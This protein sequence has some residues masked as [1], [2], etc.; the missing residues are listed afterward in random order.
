[1]H[2]ALLFVLFTSLY[3]IGNE[4]LPLIDR[5][6]P[7]FA[8]A[9]REMRASGDYI[10]PRVN[11]EYRFDKPP[12]IYWLQVAA[13]DL[14]GDNEFAVRFP[15]V[16]FAAA[17][18]VA[19]A[20]WGSR[21]YNPKT[22][23]WAGLIFGLSFQLFIHA[24]AAVA[25]FPM[26]FCFLVATWSAWERRSTPRSTLLFWAFYL[27]LGIGF[28]AKGPIALLPILFPLLYQLTVR[29]PIRPNLASALAGLGVVLLVIGAWGVPALILT[30]GEF[31]AVGIGHHVVERSI[32]PL[33]SHGARTWV[34][35]LLGLP[36]YFL[37]FFFSFFPGWLFAPAA[38]R[39]L[40]GEIMPVERYLLIAAGCVFLVF[41][42]IQTKLPH[43]TLPALPFL[44]LLIAPSA[45][46]IP[47]SQRALLLT[48]ATYALVALVGFRLIAPFFATQ[49]ILERVAG[50]L[51]PDTR[52]ATTSYDEPSLIWSLRKTVRPFLQRVSTDQIEAFLQTPG[53]AVCIVT[54]EDY[55]HLPSD[56]NR[57]EYRANGYDFARWKT[58]PVD[59]LGLKL[60]LP[61]PEPVAAIV[62]SK[63][64]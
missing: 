21:L 42:L 41:T 28:L 31:F 60:P 52:I 63:E 46:R 14:L 20:F 10:I 2:L 61:L 32:A 26:I 47:W 25:D 33:Q 64:R 13:I 58:H 11:G 9:S 48:L 17:A 16:L 51:E 24:R 36:F 53:S 38:I 27:A 55:N 22:G 23:L 18:V 8:E 29:E 35:Y 15:S 57:L 30:H 43:Y 62:V 56:P 19:L 6:E 50:K 37:T 39:R 3:S 59:V 44:S 40:R 4:A 7:R 5:D 12:L 49:A 54:A 45:V 1:L 34:G